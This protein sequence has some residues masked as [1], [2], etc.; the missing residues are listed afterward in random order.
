MDQYISLLYE[1]SPFCPPTTPES[2]AKIKLDI[3]LNNLP[4]IISI[5]KETGLLG[6]NQAM[7]IDSEFHWIESSFNVTKRNIIDF[8]MGFAIPP[9]LMIGGYSLMTKGVAEAIN[10]FCPPT[11][12]PLMNAMNQYKNYH[13]FTVYGIISAT[14]DRPPL[15]GAAPVYQICKIDAFKNDFYFLAGV[16]ASE[17]LFG[18]L[19]NLLYPH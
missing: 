17:R 19:T 10:L 9:S 6:I 14:I 5:A 8:M 13:L 12:D 16:N 11:D 4:P 7:I 15:V 3:K 2:L 1:G 18:E